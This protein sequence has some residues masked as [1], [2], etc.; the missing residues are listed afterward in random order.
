MVS[1]GFDPSR[2]YPDA[3]TNANKIVL[4]P[5]HAGKTEVVK[6][7]SR[8]FSDGGQGAGQPLSI[9]ARGLPRPPLTPL[10]AGG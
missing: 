3:L 2:V 1:R 6:C 5:I 9:R 7:N 4:D 10:A 8:V